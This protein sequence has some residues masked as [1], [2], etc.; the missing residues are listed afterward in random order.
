MANANP[1]I[2]A[3]ETQYKGYR[4]RSRL[5]ARWAV[6]FDALGIP[7]EYEPEGFETR[8]GRYLP[9]FRLA[10]GPHADICRDRDPDDDNDTHWMKVKPRNGV[11]QPAGL[12]KACGLC[13]G[14]GQRATVL[15]GEPYEDAYRTTTYSTWG[16]EREH[17]DR[18]DKLIWSEC[19]HCRSVRLSAEGGLIGTS[20]E[21]DGEYPMFYCEHCDIHDRHWR[22]SWELEFHK[23][24]WV[25]RRPGWRSTWGPRLGAAF[26]RARSARF[27]YG[28]SGA[29]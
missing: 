6:F 10:L 14:T 29:L 9:D 28:A 15:F 4:F 2:K 26:Q 25:V 7:W 8:A 17:L 24:M 11:D 3:I 13:I 16:D 20:L 23:G 12:S 21:H 27:E 22:E 19:P 1:P 18:N 5:E